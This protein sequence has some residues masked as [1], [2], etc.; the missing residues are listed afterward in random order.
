MKYLFIA[1]ICFVSF[2]GHSQSPV[3]TSAFELYG[4][5][6][7]VKLSVDDS[8]PLDFILDTGD[9]LTVIDLDVAKR[10][11][12]PLDHK[13]STTSA[14]GSITG[15]LIK[16]N[17]VELNDLVLEK[18][19]KIYATGLKHLEISIGRNIDGIIGYDMLHHHIVRLNY[20][21]KQI[22][23]YDSG[24]Y[25][26]KG[27]EMAFKFHTA[28][29]VISGY[30]TLNNGESIEGD[31]FLNTGAGTTLDFNTP[32][33]NANG[34]IDKTGEH[35]SYFVKGL[36]NKET[37]HYEGR[38]KSLRFG[39]FSFE[40]LPIGISQVQS[41]IQGD[42]KMA[43]IIGNKVLSRFNILFD[44]KLHK[45]YLEE[46]SNGK[47]DFTVNC[48]GIDVQMDENL[49]KV[50]IH[51]VFEGSQAEAAGI[52]LNDEIVNVNGKAVSG[53]TLIEIEDILKKSGT[54]VSLTLNQGGTS[55]EV[56]LDL[57]SIL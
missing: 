53:M 12:L 49:E 37:K 33:A 26:K 21:L 3:T 22:E 19:I 14:Q 52:K 7:F 18:N 11:N 57:K 27:E 10:L 8:E 23:V 20:D 48:S 45:I 25:P 34:I 56:S 30:I 55:K 24:S 29:P 16:H 54:E 39:S 1:I 50:L 47:K 5:H 2:T 41:G 44:Y 35:Y 13:Q 32:F 43:G 17:K 36:G 15:A 46:N 9:G 28:I 31:F 51:Q 6:I 4:D 38:V 42:K 40:D